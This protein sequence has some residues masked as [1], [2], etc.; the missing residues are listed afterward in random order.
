MVQHHRVQQ[1]H[2]KKHKEAFDYMVYFF[3]V[4]TPLFE[5]PQAYAIHSSRNAENV[6]LYTW[7]FFFMS[8]IVWL[9]YSIKNKLK[10]LIVMYWMYL[11]VEATVVTGIIMY[12]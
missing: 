3:M 10:P 2:K 7:G 9:A 11:I 1:L 4:A 5:V 8:S 6:S 12:S